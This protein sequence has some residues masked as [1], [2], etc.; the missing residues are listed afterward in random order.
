MEYEDI[1][2]GL[3]LGLASNAAASAAYGE[4]SDFDRQMIITE[5]ETINNKVRM[6]DLVNR[7]GRNRGAHDR[8]Y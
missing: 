7:I 8:F 2:L 3:A 1:P 5:A 4:M 6:D